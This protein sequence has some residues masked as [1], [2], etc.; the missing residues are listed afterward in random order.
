MIAIKSLLLMRWRHFDFDGLV[1]SRSAN[2]LRLIALASLFY[3]SFELQKRKED[4]WWK[5]EEA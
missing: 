1:L 3:S 4:W 2:D 5:E